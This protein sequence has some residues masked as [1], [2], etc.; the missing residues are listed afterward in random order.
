M[1][2]Y[3]IALVVLD[4]IIQLCYM[5]ITIWLTCVRWLIFLSLILITFKIIIHI[6]FDNMHNVNK[7]VTPEMYNSIIYNYLVMFDLA[8]KNKIFSKF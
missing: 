6:N 3:L 1:F 8:K 4:I 5:Y 7:D 2:N